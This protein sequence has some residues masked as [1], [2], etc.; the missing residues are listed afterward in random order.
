MF[1]VQSIIFP[2]KTKLESFNLLSEGVICSIMASREVSSARTATAQC[3]AGTQGKSCQFKIVQL[4]ESGV[5]KS[6]LVLRFAKGM[7][8]EYHESTIGGKHAIVC[9]T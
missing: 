1:T 8:H 9:L 5:G 4:G 7:F 6:S 3:P 2:I